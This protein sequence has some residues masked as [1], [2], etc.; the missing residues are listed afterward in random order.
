[1]S[2][3]LAKKE[4]ARGNY[5]RAYSLLANLLYEFPQHERSREIR[6]LLQLSASRRDDPDTGLEYVEPNK[7]GVLLPQTGDFSRFGRYFE[8]GARL[9][10]DDFNS[11]GETQISIVLADTRADPVDAGIA[12]RKLVLEQ[13]VLAV[14][15][16]VF[17]MPKQANDCR[18]PR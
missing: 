13:G 2:L 7:I 11:S 9:A 16:S 18:C 12:A 14:L 3:G 5:D 1:M 10:V 17:T 4:Y 8:E 15:G 6:Y